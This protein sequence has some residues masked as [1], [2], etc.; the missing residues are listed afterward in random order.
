TFQFFA[1]CTAGPVAFMPSVGRA[2]MLDSECGGIYDVTLG[3]TGYGIA[4]TFFPNILPSDL[5][6]I[7]SDGSQGYV[8]GRLGSTSV[9][10]ASATAVMNGNSVASVNVTSPGSRY[11]GAPAVQFY[12]RDQDAIGYT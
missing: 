3:S 6:A 8:G 12:S 9:T 5:I 10:S 7:A 4:N 2:F 11:L 1:Q